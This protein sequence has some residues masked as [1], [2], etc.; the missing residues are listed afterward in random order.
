MDVFEFGNATAYWIE[1]VI[2]R[3][4]TPTTPIMVRRSRTYKEEAPAQKN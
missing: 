3:F 4:G 1:N 2:A